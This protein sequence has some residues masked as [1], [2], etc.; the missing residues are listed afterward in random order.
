MIKKIDKFFLD[1]SLTCYGLLLKASWPLPQFYEFPEQHHGI[2]VTNE[3]MANIL[4]WVRN[5]VL[6]KGE[7][8]SSKKW[9]VMLLPQDLHLTPIVLDFKGA[10][11]RLSPGPSAAI[12]SWCPTWVLT[13]TT[14]LFKC[15]SL[16]VTRD[17]E[18]AALWKTCFHSD[19]CKVSTTSLI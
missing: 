9:E 18:T 6:Q 16:V 12:L 19:I 11:V 14:L 3:T 5:H 17:I 13:E 4:A 2:K 7:T 10:T 15:Q 8:V 1:W